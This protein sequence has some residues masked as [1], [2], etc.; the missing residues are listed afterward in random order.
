MNEG[1]LDLL[2]ASSLDASVISSW[3]PEWKLAF[4]SAME[5]SRVDARVHPVRVSYYEKAIAAMV[6]SDYPQS[7][8]W[9]LL[10]TWNLAAMVLPETGLKTWRA[11][12]GQLGFAADAFEERV[13]GLDK[14][15]DGVE[16]LLDELAVANGL[17][18]STSL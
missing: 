15:L 8:L 16:D 2:G 11:A 6:E 13:E 5:S 9:P 18:T 7:A 17:A 3:I 1:L 10:Y 14:Y 4:E 12:C